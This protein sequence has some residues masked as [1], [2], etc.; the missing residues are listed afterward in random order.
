MTREPDT[1]SSAPPGERP[2]RH[3]RG[4]LYALE[5]CF[6]GFIAFF[7]LV[8]FVQ[9]LGYKLVSSRT[10]F[11]IM[12]PLGI[13]IVVHALRLWRARSEFHPGARIREALSGMTPGMNAVL[14]I[15][16]WMLVM[17]LMIL[18]LGHYAGIFLFCVILMRFLAGEK[19]LLTILVSAAATFF[20]FAV[21]EYAFN[22]DLYRGLI[23]R[24]FLGF[25]DF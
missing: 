13:L 5:I 6:L 24:Y 2:K 22:I 23:V 4:N 19:W 7:V 3:P 14:G 16:A 11:V 15:S 12:V 10:P 21:F 25:R 17:V 9:A 18:V 8:A 20:I 1:S